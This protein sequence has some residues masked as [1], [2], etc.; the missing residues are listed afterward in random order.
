MV[1]N[2]ELRDRIEELEL[3]LAAQKSETTAAKRTCL[4]AEE[5]ANELY[6]DLIRTQEEARANAQQNDSLI[7]GLRALTEALDVEQIFSGMLKVLRDVL[8]FEDAFILAQDPDERL[9]T[10]ASTNNLFE[11]SIWKP[12][13]FFERILKGKTIATFDVSLI[14]EWQQQQSPSFHQRAVS[15]VH[16][17]V[18]T[19]QTAAILVCIHSAKGFFTSKHVK[20]ADRF[21]ILA[22][23]ALQN[24]ELYTDLR[25]ERD[26][27]EQRVVE[28]TTE[29]ETLARFPEENPNPVFRVSKDGEFQ[30]SNEAGS[31][32]LSSL[33]LEVGALVPDDWHRI[34][35]TAYPANE[36]AKEE[37]AYDDRAFLATFAPVPA[38]GYVNIYLED[39]T[40]RKRAEEALL[41]SQSKLAGI[42]QSAMD[43]IITVN[44]QG[45]ITQFNPAAETIFGRS[46]EETMGQPLERLLPARFRDLHGDYMHGFGQE[47]VSQ[48]RMGKT[49]IVQ[50][51]RADGQE[52]PLE[53]SISRVDISGRMYFTAIVRDIT[54]RQRAE[55]D[56]RDQNDFVTTLV[57]TMAQGLIVLDDNGRFE[58]VNP[59]FAQML[60]YEP[61]DLIGKTPFDITYAD[62]HTM[63]AQAWER[64]RNGRVESFEAR[65]VGSLGR[66]IYAL[67]IGT[68]RFR[69]GR[70]A[71]TIGVVSDLTERRKFEEA[72]QVS[73][74]RTRLVVETSLDAVVAM[75]MDG[76]ITDWNGQAEK[77]FGWQA[78]E[79][80]GQ[81]MSS[82]IIPHQY[83][84]AHLNGLSHYK[85]T[86]E[87]PV[88]NK[89]IE[90][91]G[92]HWDGR[93]FPIELAITPLQSGDKKIFSA[94]IRD[95]SER[96]QTERALQ[97]AKEVAEEAA[98]AKAAF[99]AS[100][101]H[102]I[103]TPLNAVL[104]LTNLLLDTPLSQQQRVYVDT[105][106]TSGKS[107]LAIIN[108][109][110][111]FSKFEAGKLELEEHP[112]ILSE[113]IQA[114][115]ELIENEARQK[116]LDLSW[117][118]AKGT[119]SAFA[120]DVS[121]LRQV[122]VNLLSN[123]VKFTEQGS[124][125]VKVNGSGVDSDQFE[126][127]FR[128]EDSG[129]GIPA[130]KTDRL[131]EAFAQVDA[132]VTRKYGGTGLGLAISRQLVELMGGRIWAE[133]EP[134]RGSTFHFTVTLPIARTRQVP[135]E[136]QP[137]Q[138]DQDM[139]SK[140]PLSILL[141][142]DDAVNQMVALHML[143]KLGYH[144]DVAADGV[145]VLEALHR[146]K[147]DVILMD[148]Q[149]PEMDGVEA[150]QNIRSGWPKESQPRIIAMTAEALEGDRERFLEAGM[151]DYVPKP[152]MM[153]ELTAA[154]VRSIPEH[155]L[156]SDSLDSDE[157][158]GPTEE[159]E[160]IDVANF[161]ERL[162]PG[163]SA[164]LPNLVDL[165]IVEA[166]PMILGLKRAAGD[167][168]WP[169]IESLA[170]RLSGSSSNI[171]ALQF[172]A[173]CQLLRERA[174]EQDQKE[175]SRAVIK[176]EQEYESITKWREQ[177]SLV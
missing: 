77:I 158:V 170:H 99:L 68:P 82:T 73:E 12:G 48:R 132:S 156:E 176:L 34:I 6:L 60:D 31:K 58:F 76:R 120:G 172:A 89:R 155:K 40:D 103:R 23:N 118:V 127:H 21:A 175:V 140:F 115:V 144:A 14:P 5:R 142:E 11:G 163:S 13:K 72:L 38:A 161:E 35:R 86:G 20:L 43:G 136:D 146:Q 45:R 39:N 24:A 2:V 164:L 81:K 125:T 131:F 167:G 139:G 166:E 25:H 32:F 67:S 114:T 28:R 109:I 4:T 15:A 174:K 62:D 171:S 138:I 141:A 117:R 119:P 169:K 55:Q 108:E 113:F 135:E 57:N 70:F 159:R 74:A 160:P 63:L 37:F 7:K 54:E 112:F 9:S 110:L 94:F 126:L 90:I 107:L 153:K 80:I 92:L 26:T 148:R 42:V 149:M 18:S 100:M 69:G 121:R 71:G 50:G 27:L 104:G 29:V 56:L 134:G 124:V 64:Q 106:H 79:I 44:D 85:A 52:F 75:D 98:E 173:G 168:N 3:L 61:E 177:R 1:E 95:I 41:E 49:G 30:Y 151:D 97:K 143:E 84:K 87:G 83:R 122:L 102:E 88:L 137:W 19:G 53:G 116:H 17:P 33:G 22:T 16:V 105:V 59:A 152:I 51:V 96:K 111:D 147:Y 154:L 165:F 91:T 133:S 10:V 129:I 157:V 150:M 36:P 123:A 65:M 46:S 47:S 93:E 8:D 145:E 101:S 128:I 66:E 78:D 130:E 162:G